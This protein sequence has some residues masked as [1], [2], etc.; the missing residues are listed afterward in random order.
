MTQDENGT[1]SPFVQLLQVSLGNRDS[2]D[3][4]QTLASWT[5]IYEESQRQSIVG[6]MLFGLERLPQT[7]RP[8][9]ELLLQWIG[10]GEVLRQQNRIVSARCIEI[11]KKLTKDGFRSCLLK[12]QGNAMMYPDSSRRAAGDIDIWVE[13]GKK[14]VVRYV[15]SLYPQI[16]IEY[17]HM[18]FPIFEDVEVEVHYYPSFCYNK[19]HNRRLLKYFKN[20]SEEQFRHL[21]EFEW[22]EICVPTMSF[23][24][25]FQL[26]H[27]MRHFFTQ[28]IGLRH[29]VDYYYLLSQDISEKEKCEAVSVIKRC[30]MYK[31]LCALLWVEK[32]VL[33]LRTNLDIAPL[34]EKA[35][36]MVFEEMLKGGNFGKSYDY[37]KS[38]GVIG[39]YARQMVHSLRFV[40]EFPSEPLW[41]PLAL[42]WDYV[43]KRV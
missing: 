3:Y 28:G 20:A 12:G 41:R 14:N 26:S 6:I 31:F 42:T 2:L 37:N 36:L 30:G 39:R 25:V 23:N 29:A 19:I 13:G 9:T 7:Q 4:E 10:V 16:N 38:C 32:E 34:D 22:T 8:L 33:G 15:H 1:N 27:M 24:L 43:K 18:Q 40:K 5:Q 17:H 11:F 35:G 21:V